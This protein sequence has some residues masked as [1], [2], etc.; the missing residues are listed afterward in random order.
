MKLHKKSYVLFNTIQ[1]LSEYYQH[2]LLNLIRKIQVGIYLG[3][4]LNILLLLKQQKIQNHI[5]R[6]AL[7]LKH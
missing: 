5:L 4:F 2:C 3:L 1:F 6:V 7:S